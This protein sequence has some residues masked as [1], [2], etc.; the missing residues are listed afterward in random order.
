[1]RAKLSALAVFAL[2]LS[3]LAFSTTPA[4]AT[5][6][7]GVEPF[8]GH[9]CVENEVDAAGTQFTATL[10]S[11]LTFK[12]EGGTTLV[13]CTGS[14]LGFKSTSAG[15]SES[16]VGISVTTASF[17]GCS[18]ALE[19]QS[20]PWEGGT[21]TWTS[22]TNN[23]TMAV[24]SL[25]LKSTFFGVS[26]VYGGLGSATLNGGEAASLLISASVPKVSGSFLCP[27]TVIAQGGYRVTE[28]PEEAVFVAQKPRGIKF[29][30]DAKC[31]TEYKFPGESEL[32]AKLSKEAE[33]KFDYLKN[34][35]TVKCKTAELRAPFAAAFS[36]TVAT[37]TVFEFGTCTR[38]G[39]NVNVTP[40][41]V[42]YRME[43]EPQL[44]RGDGG[45]T[46]RAGE[47]S[48]NPFIT[49]EEPG[50]FTCEYETKAFGFGFF[51]GGP[52]QMIT[53]S[54]LNDVTSGG[55]KGKCEGAVTMDTLW[56]ATLPKSLWIF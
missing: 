32:R 40:F 12:T 16:N 10:E 37:M 39:N 52:A 11:A 29:C 2:A 15:G 41:S 56:E 34:T 18:S 49:I 24:S 42:K 33:F 14:Q 45:A 9:D 50:V 55:S 48:G 20:L 30:A 7:C 23:G 35:T 1:M 6:L 36:P 19:A 4:S 5:V 25:R 13:E 47:S 8:P 38:A 22:G 44:G 17:T 27:G 51:A 46:V 43:L 26:C 3:G 54:T 31:A 21:V 28:N 53:S